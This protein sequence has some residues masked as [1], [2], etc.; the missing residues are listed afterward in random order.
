M[1]LEIVK[2]KIAFPQT[3]CFWDE[4]TIA[5][6]SNASFLW[7]YLPDSKS[8]A[9][10]KPTLSFLAC[11][12]RNFYIPI[13]S[14]LNFSLKRK[15]EL[16]N[17][18]NRFYFTMYIQ[19]VPVNQHGFFLKVKEIVWISQ[20]NMISIRK[21]HLQTRH[22]KPRSSNQ[23]LPLVMLINENNWIETDINWYCFYY[24]DYLKMKNE[25]Y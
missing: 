19:E 16:Y 25:D 17:N 13:K 6:I 15:L 18:H 24:L 7:T 22:M 10:F 12:C 4:D 3:I 20:F 9:V 11:S 21:G 5:T 2:S 1:Y 23:F 14:D 8:V